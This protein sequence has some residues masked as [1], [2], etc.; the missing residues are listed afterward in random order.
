[1]NISTTVASFMVF[2]AAF[3][4]TAAAIEPA[5]LAKRQAR[6]VHL[7][8]EGLPQD[9][10]GAA[11]T[12]TIREAPPGT[13]FS[14]MCWSCGYCGLQCLANG[15][16]RLIYSVWDPVDPHDYSARADA[17]KEDIRAKVLYADPM[18]E[19]S[20]FGGE[21]T[22]AKTMAKYDWEVGVP[23]RFRV[24]TEAEGTN[25]T[26]FTCFLRDP[27]SEGGWRK[28]ATISTMNRKGKA[29]Q[30]GGI[31]SFVEDFRRNYDSAKRVRRAEFSDMEVRTPAGWQPV[32]RAMFTAD[33]TPSKN[34]DAGRVKGNPR[35]FFLS[36]GGSTTNATTK[37]WAE[38]PAAN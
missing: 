3:A 1:M 18:M 34:I 4:H 35:A 11:A 17:V 30:I 37:L 15:E 2:A 27:G 20:R 7:R 10:T 23:V 28:L 24:E 8:Y 5:E 22:G 13:Y 12:V 16:H 33:P 26:A 25:R 21:G 9:V 32:E 14:V 31:Y 36:T 38:I 6:S 19:V 29:A